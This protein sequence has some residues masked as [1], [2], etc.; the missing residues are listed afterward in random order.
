[1][2]AESSRWDPDWDPDRDSGAVRLGRGTL[3]WPPIE[4]KSGRFG[5]VSL[6]DPSGIPA[7]LGAEPGSRGLEGRPPGR[8][9]ALVLSGPPA[10]GYHDV[11][12]KIT[13]PAPGEA[14][15]LGRGNLFFQH[16]AT[17]A[18]LRPTSAETRSDDGEPWL[19]ET[20]LYHLRRSEVELLF[21]PDRHALPS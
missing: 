5:G 13:P 19:D 9:I 2:T 12:P 20:A 8:L 7:R 21:V 10:G 17:L 6:Y 15:T 14:H 1:M 11:E 3:G 16:E 18:G 4:R